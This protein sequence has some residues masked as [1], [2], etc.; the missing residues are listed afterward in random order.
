MRINWPVYIYIEKISKIF[1]RCAIVEWGWKKERGGANRKALW[2]FSKRYLN[3]YR[4]MKKGRQ[5]G[6][7]GSH[8]TINYTFPWVPLAGFCVPF[9]LPPQMKPHGP[10]SHKARW[11]VPLIVVY[12]VCIHFIHTHMYSIL[13]VYENKEMSEFFAKWWCTFKE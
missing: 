7:M 4:R 10:S 11:Q 8:A 1:A 5:R 12:T 13:Y 9:P 2:W 6:C 3:V